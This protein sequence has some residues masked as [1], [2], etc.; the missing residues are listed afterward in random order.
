[1]S[2]VDTA[3]P[4]VGDSTCAPSR[5][6]VITP[7]AVPA[8]PTVHPID[9]A[10]EEYYALEEAGQRPGLQSFCNRH[11]E[12]GD[13]LRRLL[14]LDYNAEQVQYLLSREDS[15]L[16]PKV[17]EQRG[18]WIILRALG[19]GR[20]SRVYLAA[21]ESTGGRHV[22]VK[23]SYLDG[24]EARTLGRLSHPHIVPILSA[25]LEKETALTVVCMP[26]L[27]HT[28]LEHV[29]DRHWRPG[30]P[31]PARAAE[32]LDVVRSSAGPEDRPDTPP[33]PLLGQGSYTD[34]VVHLAIALADTLAFVHARGVL[35]RD[36]KPSN[37]LLDPSG[38]PL[39][40]DF[41][42]SISE[43]EPG[44]PPGGTPHYMAPEQLRAFLDRRLP[45]LD[46]RDD[47]FSLG[48]M[49]YELLTGELPCGPLPSGLSTVEQ[50]RFLLERVQGGV[51]PLRDRCP[52]LERPVAAVLDRCLALDPANR[53]SSAAELAAQLRRQFHPVRRM[54]RWM[55]ARPRTVL[56]TLALLLLASA[57]AG[58]AWSLVPPYG[59][60]RYA[61]GV[62][63][64]H[65]G[66]FDEAETCFTEALE[67]EPTNSRYRF[68]RGC[69]RLKQSKFL[70]GPSDKLDQAC[71]DLLPYSSRLDDQA[72]A[73]YAYVAS[74]R[75]KPTD[76]IR[77]YNNL[78]KVG[79][80][81][82]MVRNNRAFNYLMAHKYAEASLDLQ[83]AERLGSEC[84]A[85]Y[86]NRAMLELILWSE[87]SRPLLS[88]QAI[89]D[90]ERALTLGPATWAL[91][92]DAARLYASA[93]RD[94]ARGMPVSIDVPIVAA[95]QMRSREP[96][97]ERAI[98]HL[99][100]A[101]AEGQTPTAL[102]I[103]HYF[104]L[105]LR[106]HPSFIELTRIPRR[107]Q[108]YLELRLLDPIDLPQ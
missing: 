4:Q 32:I 29:C 51:R 61:A 44:V 99:R 84:Q 59:E 90:I 5:P 83:E 37:V 40:L 74:R 21:E 66:R 87:R 3:T 50:A 42:L 104:Q 98:A 19:T 10:L 25:R 60:R 28:T 75:Q 31:R 97:I 2:P 108:V 102:T 27:G 18:D 13:G 56:V 15:I 14:E 77:W 101:V 91:H 24:A 57:S 35:H 16:W 33:H 30:H 46:A 55:A 65:E 43:Q 76:A 45:V 38:K 85:V 73:V 9:R 47:L 105:D 39:L 96:L 22:V 107:S 88:P 26:Y 68:A 6:S 23:F 36:L 78:E 8:E 93:A 72:L 12:C 94:V 79:Y 100:E 81:P 71:T 82:L 80:R 52:G 49:I 20:F 64:Y 58:F 62:R 106:H 67:S 7:S 92:R 63:A 89:D 11:P 34:G 17:G 70:L 103:D 86:Y 41:N 48:V 95:L 53:P 69:T 1:M 54:R